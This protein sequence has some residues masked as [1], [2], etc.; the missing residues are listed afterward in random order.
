MSNCGADQGKYWLDKQRKRCSWCRP[1]YQEPPAHPPAP[2][3]PLPATSTPAPSTASTPPINTP[4]VLVS[5]I[6]KQ[7]KLEYRSHTVESKVILLCDGLCDLVTPTLNECLD[8]HSLK[9]E[10]PKV[11]VYCSGYAKK[12]QQKQ[13]GEGARQILAEMFGV[14]A[15]LVLRLDLNDDNAHHI[16]LG[17]NV[18]HMAGGNTGDLAH[19]WSLRPD[20]ASILRDRVCSGE[21]LYIGSSA[22]SFVAGGSLVYNLEHCS[23]CRPDS[24]S[25]HDSLGLVNLNICVYHSNEEPA[26]FSES[27]AQDPLALRIANR[28]GILLLGA[29][30]EPIVLKGV[31]TKGR[32][33]IHQE[34][35]KLMPQAIPSQVQ[36]VAIPEFPKTSGTHTWL[37]ASGCE[38]KYHWQYNLVNSGKPPLVLFWLPG[39]GNPRD[40]QWNALA[41]L[42]GRTGPMA[43]MVHNDC[44]LVSPLDDSRLAKQQFRMEL[45]EWITDLFMAVLQ[46]AQG[47]V[48]LAGFSRGA[49]W[50]GEL[51]AAAKPNG[52]KR[53]LL[54][55]PY[56]RK[57]WT[58]AELKEHADNLNSCATDLVSVYTRNDAQCK[59]EIVKE[60]VLNCGLALD[61]TQNVQNHDQVMQMFCEDALPSVS[62]WL[63]H[64]E[65]IKLVSV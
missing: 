45:P 57:C 18:L 52:C 61:V 15:D 13:W 2:T 49:K 17:C 33:V 23:K 62:S 28:T 11:A 8:R 1:F 35:M 47:N 32:H 53:A 9:P 65:N 41:K 51:V 54:L 10:N 46:H 59:W 50:A 12:K 64:G 55:A 30:I 20:L 48:A 42:L 31:S 43:D 16:L 44:I 40:S 4:E 14:D 24:H 60:F 63:L 27:L 19:Q 58:A 38:H 26:Q 21:I 29:T 39:C 22:G 6:P 36:Q 56:C 5:P 34:A 25:R 3:P 7:R 37:D